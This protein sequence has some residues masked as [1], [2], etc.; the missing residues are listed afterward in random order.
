M[1]INHLIETGDVA[2][3]AKF[4]RDHKLK[5]VDGKLVPVDSDANVKL[6]A[7]V[8][9]W[10]QRQQAR[11]ILLNSLYG[12]LLNEALRF[13]DER[14]GQSVTLSGRSIARHMNAKIN[15][16][17]T[18]T[19]DHAGEA[20][21]YADTD[22]SYFSASPMM[23]DD[24]NLNRDLVVE[25]YLK[26]ADAANESFPGFMD[27]TFNTGL[28]RGSVIAAGLELIAA[29]ALFIKKKKYACLK[30]WD[31]DNKRLDQDNQPGKL[32]AMGLDLKRADTPKFMQ[33]FLERILMDALQGSGERDILPQIKDFRT[34]FKTRPAW[35]KGSPKKVQNLTR[36]LAVKNQREKAVLFDKRGSRM[37]KTTSMIPGHV[38]A[39]INWNT[40]LDIHHDKYSMRITDGSRI[41]VCKLK[42]NHLNMTSVAYP[43]DEPHLPEWFKDL[44]F[45]EP[46]MEQVIIDKKI[47]NLF[48]VMNWNL[49]ATHHSDVDDLVKF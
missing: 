17:I 44:P 21:C 5:V 37:E 41:I 9:F 26:V 29:K 36:Y 2:G 3:I 10:D 43:V 1:D 24:F 33:A 32:K 13:S 46:A 19:Y 23:N 47:D 22:S 42:A 18:G 27:R 14:M 15:E 45:D 31:D 48:G 39:S 12:A 40:L 7:L 4:C 11:K 8:S 34:A 20:I 25:L 35:E 28:E 16:V 38:L 6:K 49:K 30:F